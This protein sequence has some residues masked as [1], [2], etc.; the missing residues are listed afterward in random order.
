MLDGAALSVNLS[1]HAESDLRRRAWSHVEFAGGM[2]HTERRLRVQHFLS[3]C[4]APCLVFPGTLGDRRMY[5]G[6]LWPT[7]TIDS[8]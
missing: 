7:Q 1:A 8:P 5:R 4:V 3:F 2:S 6:A